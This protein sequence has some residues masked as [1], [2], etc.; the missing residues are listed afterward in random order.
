V[1]STFSLLDFV[2]GFF[3]LSPSYSSPLLFLCKAYSRDQSDFFGSGEV[4]KKL[5]SEVDPLKAEL[6]SR[7]VELDSERQGCQIT[8]KALRAQI[9]D[10]EQRK[11]DTLA[12]LKEAFERYDSF[13]RDCEG[14]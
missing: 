4:E 10:S 5:V 11:D 1:P 8:E 13:K 3:L 9:G 7:Q 12:A 6:A 2:F 14:I